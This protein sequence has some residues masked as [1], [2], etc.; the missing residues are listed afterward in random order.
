MLRNCII[1]N[2][3]FDSKNN[4]AKTCSD[5]CR[6]EKDRRYRRERYMAQCR[7]SAQRKCIICE[8]T[9]SPRGPQKMCSPECAAINTQDRA[10][11]YYAPRRAKPRQCA[12]CGVTFRPN[13]QQKACSSECAAIRKQ[14]WYRAYYES[15]RYRI[16]KQ[17]RQYRAANKEM[18]SEQKRQ[19]RIDNPEQARRQ[20]AARSHRYLKGKRALMS[21]R[22]IERLK[23]ILECP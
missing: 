15:H 14:E 17:A 6:V 18:I 1:C 12:V 3:V 4:V 22:E 2:T 21:Q 8:T 20:D 13:A 23:E 19:W 7:P 10:R 11:A 9:F 16:S 5:T